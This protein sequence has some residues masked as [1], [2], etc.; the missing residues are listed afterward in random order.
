VMAVPYI[1]PET[2]TAEPTPVLRAAGEGKLRRFLE[3]MGENRKATVGMAIV[4]FFVI[5][6]IIGPYIA[7]YDPTTFFVGNPWS[8]PSAAHPLGTTKLGQDVL[9]QMLVGTRHSLLVGI[10]VGLFSTFLA[11][12][13]GMTA[14]YVGGW[15]DDALMLFTNVFLVLP[16]FPLAIVAASYAQ[17][18]NIKGLTVIVVVLT[19]TGWAWAARVK[20]S[21]TLSLRNKD[22]VMAAKV[23]G[24]PL[25]RIIVVEILPNMGALVAASFIF[26]TIFAVLG[27]AGLEFIGLGDIN[28][29]TWGTMLYWAENNQALLQNA[30]YWFIPPGLAIGIFAVGLTLI[31]YAI[32]ELTN[33]R[34]RVQKV[35]KVK[36][37]RA[38]GVVG[39][40]TE[41]TTDAPTA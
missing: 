9:S 18:F 35:K 4:G 27:E 23:S 32:D 39:A 41:A 12:V 20:R 8:P 29:V 25:W 19:L 16:F 28:A 5:I 31:N 30:W 34:L 13:I 6:G 22:F 17:V 21:Q 37:A 2:T 11:I 36:A 24:E 38:A 1:D 10:E 14:G 40:T 7:P 3:L 15:V 33:P 26:A